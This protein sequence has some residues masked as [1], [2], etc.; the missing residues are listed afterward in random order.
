MSETEKDMEE[1]V[2][3]SAEATPQQFTL[4][5][6]YNILVTNDLMLAQVAE[7]I[8]R[9]KKTS[10]YK[11]RVKQQTNRLEEL[12]TNFEKKMQEVAGPQIGFL[13]DV[14]QLI[15]D[16]CQ[17]N[18]DQLI[19][20]ITDEFTKVNHPYPSLMAHIELARTLSELAVINLD[21]RYKEM[22]E[23]KIPCAKQ[24]QWLRQKDILHATT[25]LSELMF[26]GGKI[27]LNN[28]LMCKTALRMIEFKLTDVKLIAQCIVESD[29]LNSTTDSDKS[30]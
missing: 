16:E 25:K 26:K 30:E 13:A 6:I 9:I 19:E 28:N 15:Q 1:L 22:I 11:Q 3:N 21:L 29:K 7:A 24:I 23:R 17:V 2:N 18:I 14:A 12:R 5:A 27:N 20:S 10:I 4:T 8:Y